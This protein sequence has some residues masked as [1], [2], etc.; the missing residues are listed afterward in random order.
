LRPEVLKET[1]KEMPEQRRPLLKTTEVIGNLERLA[2][3]RFQA[4]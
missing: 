4:M 3:A 2:E 1:W